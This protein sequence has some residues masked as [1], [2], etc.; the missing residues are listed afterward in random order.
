[1]DQKRLFVSLCKQ[2]K[3][4]LVDLRK[5]NVVMLKSDTVVCY[6]PA[7]QHRADHDVY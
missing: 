5:V 7:A 4:I 1:M 3:A 6:N 2:K